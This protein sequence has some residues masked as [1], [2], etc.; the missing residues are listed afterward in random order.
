MRVEFA[1]ADVFGLLKPY[2]KADIFVRPASA[3]LRGA[4]RL[5]AGFYGSAGYRALKAMEKS[6]FKIGRVGDVAG[7]RWFGPFART[8][9]EDPSA[10]IPFLSSSEMLSAMLAPKNCLSKALTPNL[11]RLLVGEGTIL[12]SCSGTIGNVAIGTKDYD[13]FAVSQH[14]IRVDPIN[15]VDRGMLYVFLLSEL[16]QFLV[17]RN[18]SGSVIE[19]IYANDI[20]SLPLLSLPRR[21]KQEISERIQQACDLRVKA[22]ATLL[23]AD[24]QITEVANPRLGSRTLSPKNRPVPCF[25][26]SASEVYRARES[27]GYARLDSAYYEPS[28]LELRD[29]LRAAGAVRL[30]EVVLGVVLIGKTFVKGVQKVDGN[31]GIPYFT[32]KELFKNRP[33]PET[34][35]TCR[36]RAVIDR[37]IVRRGMTLIT[38][39]GTVGKVMYVSRALDGSAVTHDAIRVVPGTD[40]HSGYV[41]AYLASPVGHSQLVR[42]TYGSVIPRLYRT[43]VEGI[44]IPRLKDGGSEI[45]RLVDQAFDLRDKAL[46]IEN[47]AVETFLATLKR[48][49]SAVEQEWGKEY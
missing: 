2:S 45:G 20:E 36:R 47:A 41:Y 3:V 39:A 24:A 14:A 9:V 40:L 38:C 22:N 37:L 48:G 17:T 11:D 32:G 31:F 5:E 4:R 19:S 46:E 35:I 16:G 15:D 49:R 25:V 13:G 30:T 43:H 7:V 1:Q 27:E 18:K 10:G 23:E 29:R 34:F 26:P 12:V 6:G 42:C 33:L 44:L 21:L 28:I 8:Y